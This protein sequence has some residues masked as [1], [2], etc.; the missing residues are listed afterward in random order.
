ME[1]WNAIARIPVNDSMAS[2]I[3]DLR[4][5]YINLSAAGLI[6]IGRAAFEINKLPES[7][8]VAKYIELATKINWRR[9]ADLWQN[10]LIFDGKLVNNR[11]PVKMASDKV[12]EIIGLPTSTANNAVAA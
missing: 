8:R 9:D 3:P 7:E 11:G 12:K 10:T 1:P 4:Q 2:R 6:V 5:E